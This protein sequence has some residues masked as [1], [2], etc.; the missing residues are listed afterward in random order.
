MTQTGSKHNGVV[1]LC[2]YVATAETSGD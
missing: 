1:Y 2:Y